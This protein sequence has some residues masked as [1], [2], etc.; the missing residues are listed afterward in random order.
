MIKMPDN[1]ETFRTLKHL[2]LGNYESPQ[3]YYLCW[4]REFLKKLPENESSPE[5][6]A[7]ILNKFPPEELAPILNKFPPEERAR[8]RREFP[9][10]EV[11]F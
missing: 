4:R 5:E 3:E 8:I 11:E 10:V 9:E 7:P 6:L 1:L 2:Q